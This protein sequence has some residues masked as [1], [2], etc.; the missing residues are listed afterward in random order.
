MSLPKFR[1]IKLLRVSFIEPQ[2]PILSLSCFLSQN[3]TQN[4]DTLESLAGVRRVLQ[5]HGS[6]ATASC[7]LCHRRV[8]GSEI[9]ADI[10]RQ[11]VPLC[12]VCNPPAAPTV[13]TGKNKS[14]KKKKGGWD[15]DV[16]DESDGPEYPPGI[17][18][19]RVY[20]PCGDVR[21]AKLSFPL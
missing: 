10:L 3:Y 9:E 2:I 21:D 17:M 11:K 18:K 19:V 5:C 1:G 20:Y 12:T 6:F 13:P 8:P 7:L 14:G 16:E 15:S 4:I